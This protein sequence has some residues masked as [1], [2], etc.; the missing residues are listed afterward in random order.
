MLK[1]KRPPAPGLLHPSI[2]ADRLG[3]AG[4]ALMA[5]MRRGL[6]PHVR[7]NGRNWVLEE[8]LEDE[9]ARMTQDIAAVATAYRAEK[10]K[11]G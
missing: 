5:R 4:P 8:W 7:A 11:Q 6:V 9:L 10:E 3:M 2:V 1:D